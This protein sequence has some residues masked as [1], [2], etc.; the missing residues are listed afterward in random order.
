MYGNVA[1]LAIAVNDQI[2]RVRCLPAVANTADIVRLR[3]FGEAFAGRF[4]F[5]K[6]LTVALV[7]VIVRAV[8]SVPR[9]LLPFFTTRSHGA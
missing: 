2:L 6:V 5:I 4:T 1:L 9:T 3:S 7:A 8:A